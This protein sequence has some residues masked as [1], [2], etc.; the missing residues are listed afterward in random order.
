M[1]MIAMIIMVSCQ[2]KASDEYFYYTENKDEGGYYLTKIKKDIPDDIVIPAEVDGIPVVGIGELA[3]ENSSIKSVKIGG[4]IKKIKHAAF[5]NCEEL[6]SVVMEE[7]VEYIGGNAF[8]DCAPYLNIEIPNS[9]LWIDGS[10][11]N[12]NPARYD[13]GTTNV[14]VKV[15]EGV[16]VFHYLGNNDNPYLVLY[17]SF[18]EDGVKKYTVKESTKI[19]FWNGLRGCEEI[20]LHD[21]VI[22]VEGIIERYQGEPNCVT[23]DENWIDYVDNW[24]VDIPE[25]VAGANKYPEITRTDIIGIVDDGGRRSWEKLKFAGTMEE[26][27]RL[28]KDESSFD[29]IT[30]I[31]SDG[32]I[33]PTRKIN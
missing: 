30:I 19:V 22:C 21:N 5:R 16:G 2:K 13:D 8:Y 29:Y 18:L 4:N 10:A 32:E 20:K 9:I 25:V 11:M 27:K 24:V 23:E 15:I 14:T 33:K 6:S 1:L 3:F 17:S 12:L 26:W 28:Y 7:G 31:C